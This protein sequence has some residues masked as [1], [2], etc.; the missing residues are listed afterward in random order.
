M[1]NFRLCTYGIIKIRIR[2][3]NLTNEIKVYI[4]SDDLI[5][6]PMLLGRDFLSIFKIKMFMHCSEINMSVN[7][8]KI[9][10]DNKIN[11]L[12]ISEYTLHFVSEP[13]H[14]KSVDNKKM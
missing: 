6:Y 1:G 3:R 4:V 9:E 7:K 12:R 8:P 11:E 2:F 5:P 10:Y 14:C 13:I